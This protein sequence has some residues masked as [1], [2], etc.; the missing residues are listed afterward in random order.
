MII[1]FHTYVGK[2]M[3]GQESTEEELLENMEKNQVTMSVVCPVKTIDPFFEKQNEYIA[4]L[5]KKYPDK[6]AGFC[7]ID[8]NLGK[9]SEK[10]LTDSIEHLH[11]KG[12][13]LHPWE[14]TFAINDKKVFPF[15]EI[16]SDRKI[17]V[18]VETGYPWLSHCFQVGS[19]A[20]KY[21]DVTFIMSHGG[22]FDSSGYALTDVDYVMNKYGNLVIETSGDYSDEGIENIPVRLGESRVLFGSHF[23]W[24][25][26]ELEI[27]RVQRVNL[28]KE[29]KEAIFYKNAE[30]ILNL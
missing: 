23:P 26:T 28:P 2:S 13:V 17:P 19:L 4:E 11:L 29:C 7:R 10:L 5:Q 12:L 15:M 1:D 21:P 14:E 9:D 8:P 25:C 20:E 3:L 16:C 27:Y 22:Q 30:K 18:L 6:I 24:L